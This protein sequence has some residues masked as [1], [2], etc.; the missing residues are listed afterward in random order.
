MDKL[1]SDVDIKAMFVKIIGKLESIEGKLDESTYPTEEF[2]KSDFIERV[3]AAENE[4][5]DGN[6]IEFES[7]DDLLDSVET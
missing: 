5:S 1:H 2:F 3:K 4:I 7:M 6:Y